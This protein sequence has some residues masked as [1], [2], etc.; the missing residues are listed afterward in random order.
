MASE[1]AGDRQSRQGGGLSAGDSSRAPVSAVTRKGRARRPPGAGSAASPGTA[2]DELDLRPVQ[3]R[4]LPGIVDLDHRNTGVSKPAYWRELCQRYAQGPHPE[5][6]LV[7]E[8]DGAIEGL[9]IGEVRA[10][11]FGSEPCGWVFAVQVRRESRVRH[12]GTR[13]FAA[14]AAHFRK[15][16]VVKIRTMLR[17]DDQLNM[18]FFRSLGMMA[19]PFIQLELDLDEVDGVE[20]ARPRLAGAR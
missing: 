10:W 6:F 9:I 7:A 2:E 17:R 14:I 8:R 15:Q 5:L 1:V 13:L 16:G 11:E 4:D 19:G 3:L 18:S 20:A 12:I